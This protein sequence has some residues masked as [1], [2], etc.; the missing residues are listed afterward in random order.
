MERLSREV[1]QSS[2]VGRDLEGEGGREREEDGTKFYK[3][4]SSSSSSDVATI[5]T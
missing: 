5:L 3:Q 1:S 4:C 2:G